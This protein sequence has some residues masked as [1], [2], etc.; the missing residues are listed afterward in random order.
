LSVFALCCGAQKQWTLDECI[1]YAIDNNIQVKQG[2]FNRQLQE[3]QL[4]T[5]RNSRLPSLDASASQNYSFGRSLD[6]SNTYIDTNTRSTSFSLGTNVPLF[7][8]FQITNN[9]RISKLNLQAATAD[10][11][12]A[13]NN[14]R[15]A[16]AQ[17]Y[18]EILYDMEIA[19]VANNQIQ[20]DS[21]QVY[22]L[23]QMYKNGK[24]S[25]AELAQQRAT[26][27]QSRLTFTQ[28]ENTLRMAYLTLSQLLELP[29]PEGFSIVRPSVDTLP[30]SV[31]DLGSPEEIYALAEGVKPEVEAEK[32]RSEAAEKSISLAR[33]GYMPQLSLSA[34]L[35]SSYYK[36]S[37]FQ[38]QSFGKQINNNFNQYVGL[39]LSIPIFDRFNTRNNIRTAKVNRIVQDLQLANTRKTLYKEIQQ[40]YYNA[41]NAQ[42]KL[43]SCKEAANSADEAFRLMK[44]KYENGRANLTEF[45]E[46]KNGYLNALSNLQQAKYEY[47][48]SIHLLDFYKGKE[49]TL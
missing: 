4:S 27:E 28:A 20:I 32:I 39:N 16:V 12:K 44:A 10:L 21:F 42:A 48:Y 3:V 24:A 6:A 34:G 25:M 23:E 26:L 43:A 8:G 13:K 5:A 47:L 11:E 40:A 17:A 31:A 30:V 29:S 14:I 18:V 35:G 7:T 2:E 15:L 46:Q 37:G 45:N 1:K 22:R 36:T 9:I 41:V 19:E 49:L 38:A 33:A